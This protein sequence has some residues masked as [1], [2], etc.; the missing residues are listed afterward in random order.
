ML[1]RTL[2][3]SAALLASL[4]VQAKEWLIDVRTAK[5]S[6]ATMLPE[7]PISSSSR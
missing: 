7:P 1:M 2:L 5:N 4:N 6:R 3:L